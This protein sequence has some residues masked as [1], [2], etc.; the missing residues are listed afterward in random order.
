MYTAKKQVIIVYSSLGI[1][2]IL[3]MFFIFSIMFISIKG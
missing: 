3:L 1:G 2:L